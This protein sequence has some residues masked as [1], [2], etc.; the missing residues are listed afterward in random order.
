MAKIPTYTE[1]MRD[2]A[3]SLFDGRNTLLKD[4]DE[5]IKAH[6]Q[7]QSVPARNRVQACLDAYIRDH[8]RRKGVGKWKESVRNQKA[9]R[10]SFERSM[11]NPKLVREQ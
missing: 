6:S 8:E 1:W 9:N 11:A 3:G 2:T 4:L 5:A 7:A 10:P